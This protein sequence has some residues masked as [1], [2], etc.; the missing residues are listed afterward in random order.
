MSTILIAGG[1]GLIGSRLA[2]LLREK[3]HN[4]RILT[5]S[6]QNEEQFTWDPRSRHH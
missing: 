5:R 1:T 2:V 6:P 3:G 4:V